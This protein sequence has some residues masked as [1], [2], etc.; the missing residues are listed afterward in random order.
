MALL[1]ALLHFASLVCASGL[2]RW[3]AAEWIKYCRPELLPAI[4]HEANVYIRA[5]RF[6]TG[7]FIA[8]S[9]EILGDEGTEDAF[10]GP[11]EVSDAF[12]AAAPAYA[13]SQTH[14][15]VRNSPL[16]KH[17]APLTESEEL[18][19]YSS[20]DANARKIFRGLDP[21]MF[22][23]LEGTGVFNVC[24]KVSGCTKLESS[25]W[26]S[27][28][29]LQLECIAE[30]LVY[31]NVTLAASVPRPLG[32]FEDTDRMSVGV[33]GQGPGK[34]QTLL[35]WLNANADHYGRLR[36]EKLISVVR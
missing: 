17:Y 4:V 27:A 31:G 15:A 16:L 11:P 1:V 19:L 34:Q 28:T 18:A 35:E 6:D 9:L 36:V 5:T 20:S 7:D 12:L 14:L 26:V 8:D 25:G 29:V 30:L 33:D 23:F 13:V 3:S 10:G 24:L 22:G 21:G 32:L 2:H